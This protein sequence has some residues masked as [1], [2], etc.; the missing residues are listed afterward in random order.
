MAPLCTYPHI[1]N[2]HT[3]ILVSERPENVKQ[4]TNA[5]GQNK[6]CVGRPHMMEKFPAKKV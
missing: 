4:P 5:Q 1:H 2:K 3:A 6:K